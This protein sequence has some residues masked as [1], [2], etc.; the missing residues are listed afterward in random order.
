[1]SDQLVIMAPNGRVDLSHVLG[2]EVERRTRKVT[3]KRIDGALL[4]AEISTNWI[5]LIRLEHPNP[6]LREKVDGEDGPIVMY[7][8][9]TETDGSVST[10]QYDGVAFSFPA[11]TRVE[12]SADRRRRV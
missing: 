5:G 11:D 7:Q 10:Y 4:H 6:I 1:M 2:F 3:V 8:Y 12:F 9:V